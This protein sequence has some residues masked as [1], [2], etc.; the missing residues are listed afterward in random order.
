MRVV[1]CRSKRLFAKAKPD[2]VH[3]ATAHTKKHHRQIEW[4]CTIIFFSQMTL[5]INAVSFYFIHF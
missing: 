1:Y 3:G 4:F 5:Q 2:P